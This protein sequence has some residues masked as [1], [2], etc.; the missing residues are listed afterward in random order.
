M[1]PGVSS[2]STGTPASAA[3][4]LEVI[5]EPMASIVS[6]SGPIEVSPAAWTARAT[7]GVLGQEAVSAAG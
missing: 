6:A 4:F 2:G 5:L 3:S 1:A 7:P